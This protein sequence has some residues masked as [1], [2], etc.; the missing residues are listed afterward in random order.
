MGSQLFHANGAGCRLA[1]RKYG[2]DGACGRSQPSY[3]LSV[4]GN[5]SPRVKANDGRKLYGRQN[6]HPR[7][8]DLTMSAKIKTLQTNPRA[9]VIPCPC[10]S[11]DDKFSPRV[12]NECELRQMAAFCWRHSSRA[13]GAECLLSVLLRTFIPHAYEGEC[14]ICKHLPRLDLVHPPRV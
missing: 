9:C 5:S 13:C 11:G 7:V 12:V 4:F 8:G 10:P 14:D 2:N 6:I 1:I 3:F